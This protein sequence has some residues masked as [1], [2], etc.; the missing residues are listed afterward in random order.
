VRPVSACAL[1]AAFCFLALPIEPASAAPHARGRSHVVHGHAFVA[2]HLAHSG[3]EHHGLRRHAR[4][5][6]F[7]HHHGFSGGW[8]GAFDGF[9]VPYAP[10]LL[11]DSGPAEVAAVPSVL[12]LPVLVGIREAP[13]AQPAIIAVG[14]HRARG[15][16][17]NAQGMRS[18][19]YAA[20]GPLIIEL[21]P[22]RR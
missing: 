15:R 13:A 6:R 14:P 4:F 16:S 5:H 19:Q 18:A 20:P 9:A 21:G 11:G 17:S 2:P 12:D 3:A 7:N 8:P 10:A 22:A 1:A